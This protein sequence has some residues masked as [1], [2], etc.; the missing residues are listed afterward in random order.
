MGCFALLSNEMGVGSLK[1]ALEYREDYPLLP[2][3]LRIGAWS[4]SHSIQLAMNVLEA[5]GSQSNY[6][7]FTFLAQV[8]R[9]IPGRVV[10]IIECNDETAGLP[11][12]AVSR[13][14]MPGQPGR[15]QTIDIP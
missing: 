6:S 4:I 11:D 12:L 10:R 9:I 14:G 8:L 13:Y 3:S 7:A 15:V 5:A 1:L 2:L